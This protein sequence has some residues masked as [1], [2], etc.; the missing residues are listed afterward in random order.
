MR[1][2]ADAQTDSALCRLLQPELRGVALPSNLQTLTFGYSSTKAGRSRAA[3][4]PADLDFDH[5][6]NRSMQVSFFGYELDQEPYHLAAC[7]TCGH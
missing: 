3:E 7:R 6:S 1:C 4:Q 2:R 5:D